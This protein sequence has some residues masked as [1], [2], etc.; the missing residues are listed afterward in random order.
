MMTITAKS[1][2]RIANP[3]AHIQ[4]AA[5]LNAIRTM[6]SGYDLTAQTVRYT[7]NKYSDR[8]S[9]QLIDR[10]TTMGSYNTVSGGVANDGNADKNIKMRKTLLKPVIDEFQLIPQLVADASGLNPYRMDLSFDTVTADGDVDLSYV[11]FLYSNIEVAPG[12][13]RDSAGDRCVASDMSLNNTTTEATFHVIDMKN[14]GDTGEN[15]DASYN[16]I[17]AFRIYAK[18]NHVG[19]G[20]AN[21]T[22]GT[23]VQTWP[24]PVD[25][26]DVV[27]LE[28]TYTVDGFPVTLR[29]RSNKEPTFNFTLNDNG[30]TGSGG[31]LEDCSYIV[32][33]LYGDLTDMSFVNGVGGRLNQDCSFICTSSLTA[34][35]TTETLTT[36]ARLYAELPTYGADISFVSKTLKS[37]SI[38]ENNSD[39]YLGDI[40]LPIVGIADICGGLQC[41]HVPDSLKN[42]RSDAAASLASNF[43]GL[44]ELMGNISFTSA[45]DVS[46]GEVNVL[47]YNEVSGNSQTGSAN[48]DINGLFTI[49]GDILS[50]K[51]R[52]VMLGGT[53]TSTSSSSFLNTTTAQHIHKVIYS[54]H[55]NST[56]NPDVSNA[57]LARDFDCSCVHPNPTTGLCQDITDTSIN[58]MK[59]SGYPLSASTAAGGAVDVS[60]EI[61]ELTPQ[62][63]AF[64]YLYPWASP[65]MCAIGSQIADPYALN[66]YSDNALGNTDATNLPGITTVFTADSPGEAGTDKLNLKA[67][68]VTCN[69]FRHFQEK[70]VKVAGVD[71]SYAGHLKLNSIKAS[72]PTA[73]GWMDCS[74]GYYNVTKNRTE[75]YSYVDICYN[76]NFNAIQTNDSVYVYQDFASETTSTNGRFKMSIFG[77]CFP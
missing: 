56:T 20:D 18:Y 24:A 58:A 27:A 14:G 10:N 39:S 41:V 7:N 23:T 71:I 52:N 73:E 70:Y 31:G 34:N 19:T 74:H 29:S 21:T 53:I 35:V 75:W 48:N 46:A 57:C 61:A 63:S 64:F 37:T 15:E 3:L 40:M 26:A 5:S 65:Q 2:R 28:E 8:H 44:T 49:S 42:I 67:G 66:G 36:R 1:K 51:L 68:A 30:A 9:L 45:D 69:P 12:V 16:I 72:I 76:N 33:V 77:Y 13:D 55:G 47:A 59:P 17:A 6:Y 38:L 11:N 60:C 43:A 32:Q 50:N 4:F 54:S 62:E 25:G 22:D